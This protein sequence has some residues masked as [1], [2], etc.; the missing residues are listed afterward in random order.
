MP[1]EKVQHSTVEGVGIIE[2]HVVRGVRD[3]HTLGLRPLAVSDSAQYHELSASGVIIGRHY[4]HVVWT[5]YER[6][7]QHVSRMPEVD[8]RSALSPAR[9]KKS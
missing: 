8:R 5:E 2:V 6:R 4:G 3:G 7:L 9:F 1:G